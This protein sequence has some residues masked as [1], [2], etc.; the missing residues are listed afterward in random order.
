MSVLVDSNLWSLALRRK[1][2][3][4]SKDERKLEFE[5][6]ELIKAG[7]VRLIGPI[8]QEILSG[9]KHAS[10]FEKLRQYLRYFE[11][12]VVTQSDHEKAAEFFNTWCRK[13]WRVRPSI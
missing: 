3:D 9:I 11:D 8:R 5:L 1:P 6:R 10:E 7:R 13:V 4:L 12:V 2:G